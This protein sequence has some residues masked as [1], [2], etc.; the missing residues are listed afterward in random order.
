MASEASAQAPASVVQSGRAVHPPSEAGKA[1]LAARAQRP[2]GRGALDARAERHS[3]TPAAFDG[4]W[5][6]AINT[7]SGAC[8]PN[9]RFGVQI[10]N[11]NVVHEGRAAG[12]VSANGSV[13]VSISSG[14]QRA[15]GQGR[16]SR[17]YGTGVWR[18]Y[19]SAGTCAGTWQAGRGG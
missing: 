5:S 1:S 3:V 8:E 15:S 2:D 10:I 13:Q 19:G 14:A 16:L 11:G 9:Y 18:G 6:V 17:S 4:N 12:R 7:R